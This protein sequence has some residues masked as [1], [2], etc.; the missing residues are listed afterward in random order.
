MSVLIQKET[1]YFELGKIL[2]Q[3]H[4]KVF[5]EVEGVEIKSL[6]TCWL[7]LALGK[8]YCVFID[9]GM[10]KFK[11]AKILETEVIIGTKSLLPHCWGKI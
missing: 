1:E 10:V 6:K 8:G 11:P 2:R 7:H 3:F 9:K 4:K 5:M